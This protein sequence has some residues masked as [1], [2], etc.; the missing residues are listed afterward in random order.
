VIPKSPFNTDDIVLITGIGSGVA[1]ILTIVF[2]FVM[3]E[4]F[5]LGVLVILIT[6]GWVVLTAG[7][8]YYLVQNQQGKILNMAVWKVWL[9]TSSLALLI[10][11]LAGLTVE[12]NIVNGMETIRTTPMKYGV[13]LPWL[14]AYSISHLF[15]GFYNWE[16]K[17]QLPN[18]HRFVY[19]VLGIVCLAGSV[20]L[21]VVPSLH[22][23]MIL[24]LLVVSF[25]QVATV[26]L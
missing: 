14:V 2:G 24:L 16:K 8:S 17:E 11:I 18:S 12:L 22:T 1:W 25:A 13:I 20:A 3:Y 7:V 5:S 21:F 4:S 6:A 26:W 19:V 23:P 10:N 9:I 15:T